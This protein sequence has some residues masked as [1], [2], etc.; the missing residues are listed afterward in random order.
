M[1]PLDDDRTIRPFFEVKRDEMGKQIVDSDGRIKCRMCG[2]RY[3]DRGIKAHFFKTFICYHLYSRCTIK[4]IF[5]FLTYFFEM[6]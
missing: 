5:L 1:R 6:F 2:R 4:Y 3:F